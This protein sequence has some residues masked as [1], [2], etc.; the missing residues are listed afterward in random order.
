MFSQCERWGKT[1]VQTFSN[2]FP[3]NIDRGSCNDGSHD[4]KDKKRDLIRFRIWQQS[5]HFV[6]RIKR[7]LAISQSPG[8]IF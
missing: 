5:F 4:K 7:P 3:E 1:S 6:T 8:L 2:T